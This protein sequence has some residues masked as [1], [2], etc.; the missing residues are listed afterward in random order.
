MHVVGAAKNDH[1]FRGG[2]SFE[3]LEH[4]VE[5][6]ADVVVRHQNEGRNVAAP[7]ERQL[8]GQNPGPW[9]R[10]SAWRERYNRPNLMHHVGRGE[11]CPAAEAMAHDANG[12]G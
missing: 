3:D 10:T 12:R 1:A 5:R 2:Y 9:I 7:L 8:R 6:K 11:R 4:A